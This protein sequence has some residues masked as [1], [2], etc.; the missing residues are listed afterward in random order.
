MA[1]E[2]TKPYQIRLSEDFW[3]GIDEWRRQ[4]SG[5][6]PTRAAAIRRLVEIGLAAE[7]KPKRK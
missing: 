5:E 4:Q 7:Q 1:D 3:R 2:D 6:I